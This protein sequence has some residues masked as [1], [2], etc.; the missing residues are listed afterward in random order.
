MSFPEIAG[1]VIVES[2]IV[3]IGVSVGTAQFGQGNKEGEKK[4]ESRTGGY[5][6]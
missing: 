6:K 3:A 1:K 2:I 4:R 5:L